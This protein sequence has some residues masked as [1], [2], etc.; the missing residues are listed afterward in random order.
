MWK[1]FKFYL[2]LLLMCVAC[3]VPAAMFTLPEDQMGI[4]GAFLVFAAGGGL[5][6]AI[7]CLYMEDYSGDWKRQHTLI[8][9]IITLISSVLALGML[10]LFKVLYGT[11]DLSF[12]NL[13]F[14]FKGGLAELMLRVLSMVLSG[15]SIFSIYAMAIGEV[16]TDEYVYIRTTYI[17][18]EPTKQEYVSHSPNESKFI[19]FF[20]TILFAIVGIMANSFALSVFVLCFNIAAFFKGK[21]KVVVTLLGVLG[22]LIITTLSVVNLINTGADILSTSLALELMPVVYALVMW[23]YLL[24]FFHVEWLS[25]PVGL[26]IGCFVSIFIAYMGGLGLAEL[27]L[28]LV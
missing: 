9:K 20:M 17:N 7:Y 5:V 6:Y 16:D 19:T 28:L 23:L 11:S 18:G 25:H 1:S 10:I 24:G 14:N 26:L 2:A 3:I 13:I 22:A 15:I 21:G 12:I 8:T 27:I 4:P